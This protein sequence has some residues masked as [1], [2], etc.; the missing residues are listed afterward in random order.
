MPLNL[1]SGN[2]VN[3]IRWMAQSAEFV[4]VDDDG[5]VPI[6]IDGAVFDLPNIS[7]GW[8]IFGEGMAPEWVMDQNLKVKAPRPSDGR[9]WRRG[10]HLKLALP[11]KA[12]AY[13]FATTAVGAVNGVAALY[14]A[15][16]QQGGGAS[17]KL[18]VIKC[19]GAEHI[20]IGKGA[21]QVPQ[22]TISGWT[23]R[24]PELSTEGGNPELP[25]DDE[26]NL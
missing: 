3:H 2:A 14:D 26:I 6:S 4:S 15:F 20:K 21:T 24:P 1:S 5:K 17:G 10:F 11:D 23:D 9:D 7:T 16:E 19:S 18:P 13:E 25:F 22:L 8:G 12:G